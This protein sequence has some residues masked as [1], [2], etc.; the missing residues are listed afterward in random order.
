MAFWNATPGQVLM[1]EKQIEALLECL[2]ES[3][4]WGRV[5]RSAV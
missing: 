1:N 4:K 2:L 5:E 3:T